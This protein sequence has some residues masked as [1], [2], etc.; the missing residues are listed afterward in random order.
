MTWVSSHAADANHRRI[1]L[2]EWTLAGTTYRWASWDV[3]VVTSGSTG[4]A[5]ARWTPTGFAVSGI[6]S[7]QGE[8]AAEANIEIQNAD[9][10]VS[11]LI[12]AAG[13]CAGSAIAIWEAWLDP[14]G[15]TTVSQQEVALLA[16]LVN[17]P[18]ITA[19]TVE[20]TTSPPGALEQIP[21]PR[22]TYSTNCTFVFKSSACGYAG[23]G[24]S[25]DRTYS[26]CTA[27]SNQARFGGFYRLD[28][29]N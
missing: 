22:R 23:G 17:A 29:R 16:G 24:A 7:R 19:E 4:A 28:E 3:P 9:G 15:N 1:L 8:L 6:S 21:I 26:A 20:L 2:L 25:C 14:A 13:G 27:F 12:L 5:A 10:V 11:A 18:K